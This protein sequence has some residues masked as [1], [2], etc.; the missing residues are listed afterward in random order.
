MPQSYARARTCPHPTAHGHVYYLFGALGSSLAAT[1]QHFGEHNIQNLH[2]S[3]PIQSISAER[4]FLH[5][6]VNGS[7]GARTCATVNV[8]NS[9]DRRHQTGAIP[10]L[11]CLATDAA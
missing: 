6:N 9:R 8:R 5:R 7:T 4:S 1:K 3:N 2:T 11:F 10:L